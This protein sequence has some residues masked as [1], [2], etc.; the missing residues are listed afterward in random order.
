MKQFFMILLVAIFISACSQTEDNSDKT[1]EEDAVAEAQDNDIEKNAAENEQE[2]DEAAS[3]LGDLEVKLSGEATVEEDKITIEGES[4]LL[5]GT[6]IWSSGVTDA[7]FGSS[8]FTDTAEVQDDGSFLFEF[9]EVKNSTYVTLKLYNN[10]NETAAH[11]GEHLEKVEGPQV[12]V[13]DTH[14]EFEAKADFHIDINKEKP[15]TIPIEIPEWEEE[16]DD[17]GDPD[18]WMEAEVDSDHQYLYFY[19]KSNLMEGSQ[20][21]GN[22]MKASGIIDAFS[23]G[24]TRINPDGSFTLQVP[25]HKL[26]KGMYMPISYQPQRNTW[27][28][29][30]AA[31]GEHGEKLKGDL[32]EKDD[33]DQYAELIVELDGPDF[34]LPEDAGLTVDE[35]E[36]KIQMPDDLLFDFDESK[37]KSDAK[38]TL[39]DVIGDL[40]K[41]DDDTRID[42]NG[43]TDNT[44]DAD[45]NMGLSKKRANAVWNYLEKHGEVDKLDVQIE[46]YGDTKPIASNEDEEGQERNRRVEIVINPK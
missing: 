12:Y 42:I 43:H 10:N 11:Y 29:V 8:T 2:E 16:A 19:G 20:V 26:E 34:D 30:V 4:N 37:L 33:K 28:D 46:G 31:Y 5:P 6:K 38:G 35:D 25:Y 7:G 3:D 18:I 9:K 14:G 24:F 21:G 44:G 17:Y 41:L 27:E 36:I 13:T 32:V 15:Y 45:Y 40:K 22:L 39:D 23:S 1:V